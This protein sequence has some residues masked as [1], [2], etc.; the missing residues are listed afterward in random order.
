M[1]I[2]AIAWFAGILTI[3]GS[4]VIL[5]SSGHDHWGYTGH[6]GPEHWGE[7]K[8]EFAACNT[9]MRQ[10]PIDI[11]FNQLIS[12]NLG[13]IHFNYQSVTPEIL[14][15]GHTI[16]VNYAKGSGITVGERDFELAQFHFHTPSE[17]TVNG[18]AHDM[19]MHLV[20]KNAKGE[21]AVVGVFFRKGVHNNQLEKLWRDLPE[22]TGEK[23][24]L[25]DTSLSAASLLPQNRSY[26][27]FH[28]SLTTPPCSEGVNWFVI[29]QPQQASAEQI[30]RFS[31]IIGNNARPVQDLNN[32]FVLSKK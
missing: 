2:K 11:N 22:K 3:S 28:G 24:M 8:H 26:T 16:Q 32:R 27:H 17:N 31:K 5:A 1:K 4:G 25:S 30:A 13:D 21:L 10:S 9:G 6:A 12:A 7:L 19:E 14:N 29:K 15:N 23:K 20:H 18:K